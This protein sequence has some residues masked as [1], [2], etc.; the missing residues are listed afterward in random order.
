VPLITDQSA[1]AEFERTRVP[2]EVFQ[3]VLRRAVA[4]IEDA[5]IP[6]AVIGGLASA[7]HGRPRF[8]EDIDLL[9]RPVDAE[10]ALEALAAAGFATE[11]TFP[12]WLFKAT[13]ERVL[14]DVLFTIQGTMYLDEPMLSRLRPATFA[15]CT[16][17]VASP[18]DLLITKASSFNEATPHYWYDALALLSAPELDWDYLAERARLAPRRVLSLLV[19]A[20]SCDILVPPGVVRALAE[21]VYG[22][23]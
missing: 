22:A 10:R 8:S 23:T 13:R 17:S 18:E 9:V 19:F 12:D 1:G 2:Q 21:A 20:E 11:R 15:G 3:R 7:V 4:A 16:L 6:Y 5:G 14:V